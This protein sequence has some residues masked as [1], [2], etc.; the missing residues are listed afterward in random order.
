MGNIIF[1]RV[2]GATSRY[3]PILVPRGST[4]NSYVRRSRV[5]CLVSCGSVAEPRGVVLEQD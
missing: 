5:I 2:L 4:G 3:T 1:D